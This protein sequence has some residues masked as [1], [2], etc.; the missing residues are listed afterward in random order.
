MLEILQS[1]SLLLINCFNMKAVQCLQH[2]LLFALLIGEA[3][4]NSVL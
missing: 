2:Y 3:C 1:G 4:V